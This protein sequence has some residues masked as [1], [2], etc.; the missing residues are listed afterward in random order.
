MA[1][2]ANSLVNDDTT[3][4]A[5][6]MLNAVTNVVKESDAASDMFPS[7]SFNIELYI[8]A[9]GTRG[10]MPG[11]MKMVVASL[12]ALEP[13]S[14]NIARVQAPAKHAMAVL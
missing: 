1:I 5:A 4:R 6:A 12:P 14:A 10:I 9:P 3:T 2:L 7:R 13:N 8:S 11:I